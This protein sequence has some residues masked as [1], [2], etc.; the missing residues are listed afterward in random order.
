MSDGVTDADRLLEDEVVED[1]DAEMPTL[2]DTLPVEERLGEYEV[3][4]ALSN[5]SRRRSGRGCQKM[6]DWESMML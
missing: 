5:P 6:T 3:G 4:R 2:R 1:V